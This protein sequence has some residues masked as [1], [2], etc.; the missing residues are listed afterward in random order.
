M[1]ERTAVAQARTDLH[2]VLKSVTPQTWR[3]HRTDPVQIAAPMVFIDNPTISTSQPGLVAVTFPVVMVVDGTITAQVEQLDDLLSAVWSAAS[4]VGAPTNA[5]PAAL[6]VGGP[7]LRAQVLSV[8]IDM[9]AVTL[10]PPN[11]I[12]AGVN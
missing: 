8:T 10:C 7:S 1:T 5:G 11:L 2:A 9:A 12:N 4:K 3:V 6:D